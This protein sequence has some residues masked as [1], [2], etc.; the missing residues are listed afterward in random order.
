M[1]S[2][3][4]S[5]FRMILRNSV[6]SAVTFQMFRHFNHLIS[7]QIISRKTPHS[8]CS[9]SSGFLLLSVSCSVASSVLSPCIPVRFPGDDVQIRHLSS[10]E[11]HGVRH[12]RQRWQPFPL[13]VTVSRRAVTSFPVPATFFVPAGWFSVSPDDRL[14]QFSALFILRSLSERDHPVGCSPA[15]L[16]AFNSPGE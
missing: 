13:R 4:S 9:T 5:P 11:A 14:T 8:S 2:A 16:Q 10:G 6:D 12:R 7:H 3:F 15:R 1:S